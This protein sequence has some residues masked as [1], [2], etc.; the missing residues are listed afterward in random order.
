MGRYLEAW[1]G[2]ALYGN[3]R[4]KLQKANG[5][6]ADATIVGYV[7][8]SGEDLGLPPTSRLQPPGV[9]FLFPA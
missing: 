8:P 3:F 1:E 9:L 7:G 4:V 6:V 5:I 2:K